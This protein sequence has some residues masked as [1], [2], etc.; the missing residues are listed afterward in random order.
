MTMTKESGR[1]DDKDS[2]SGRGSSWKDAER[3]VSKKDLR[4]SSARTT[5]RNLRGVCE[6]ERQDGRRRGR[7][8]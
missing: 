5:M 8:K 7:E 4:I 3:S 6:H 2:D 1:D